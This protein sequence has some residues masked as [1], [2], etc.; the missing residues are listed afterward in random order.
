MMFSPLP[1]CFYTLDE[2]VFY[3]TPSFGRINPPSLGHRVGMARKVLLPI[4]NLHDLK[5]Q[6][7]FREELRKANLKAIHLLQ[8]KLQPHILQMISHAI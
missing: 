8:L 2:S 7:I 6:T 5:G 3:L 1:L 4:I